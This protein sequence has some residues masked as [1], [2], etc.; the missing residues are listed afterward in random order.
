MTDWFRFISRFLCFVVQLLVRQ[1]L[2]ICV[3]YLA[4]SNCLQEPIVS[5]HPH[6][7]RMKKENLFYVFSRRQSLIWSEF[8]FWVNL[9]QPFMLLLSHPA[10]SS[11]SFG[12]FH[13]FIL[14][15]ERKF[16]RFFAKGRKML[17]WLYDM[18]GPENNVD[19]FLGFVFLVSWSNALEFSYLSDFIFSSLCIRS[20]SRC[21]VWAW[22]KKKVFPCFCCSISRG[23][24]V[25][26]FLPASALLAFLSACWKLLRTILL[27]L[28]SYV[29]WLKKLSWQVVRNLYHPT[30][31]LFNIVCW[32]S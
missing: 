27:F 8:Y 3:K 7:S 32:E 12:S 1:L 23:Y 26:S 9:G 10:G 24:S 29:Y 2:S 13:P 11:L 14:S 22:K 4:D 17:L 25:L 31:M 21:L 30:L 20:C 19:I 15:M 5:F 28:V 18:V 16:V 6:L